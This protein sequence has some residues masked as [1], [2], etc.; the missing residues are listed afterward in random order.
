MPRNTHATITTERLDL[1]TVAGQVDLDGL[2][3]LPK[4]L[5]DV[6]AAEA[7]SHVADPS[8]VPGYDGGLFDL[9]APTNQ[10]LGYRGGWQQLVGQ[11]PSLT[12]GDSWGPLTGSRSTAAPPPAMVGSAR[13]S[14]PRGW[15]GCGCGR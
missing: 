15:A 5:D 8:R 1:L 14:S 4:R 9:G 6:L 11:L 12:R 7:R 10:P 2:G 3:Q 13:D